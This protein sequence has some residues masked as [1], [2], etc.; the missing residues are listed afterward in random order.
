MAK[1]IRIDVQVWLPKERVRE[2]LQWIRDFEQRDPANIH[3]QEWVDAPE[4]MLG[5]IERIFE[6]LNPPLPIKRIITSA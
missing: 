3:V 1:D 2:F 6:S 4:M 5:E